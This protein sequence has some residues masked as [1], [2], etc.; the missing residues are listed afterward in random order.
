[1]IVY[2]SASIY[3]LRGGGRSYKR[4]EQSNQWKQT[5]ISNEFIVR[6]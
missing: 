1:M 2:S 4:A 3:V 6:F 5:V